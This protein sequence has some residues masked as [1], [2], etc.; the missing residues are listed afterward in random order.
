LTPVFFYVLER[1]GLRKKNTSAPGSAQS[2]PTFFAEI[3]LA[4][5]V[6]QRRR[7]RDERSEA[8]DEGD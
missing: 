1:F 3:G 8:E 2:C 7:W 6:V 4:P 5:R